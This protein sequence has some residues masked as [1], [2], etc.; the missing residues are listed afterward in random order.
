M[1]LTSRVEKTP[2]DVI[3][4][5]RGR[6]MRAQFNG[7]GR[8]VSI[9]S[10]AK[11]ARHGELGETEIQNKNREQAKVVA[12]APSSGPVQEPRTEGV[13]ES[14]FIKTLRARAFDLAAMGRVRERDHDPE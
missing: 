4:L 7:Y 11:E 5:S 2:V 14:P 8:I 9:A 1:W 12:R 3:K 10:K 6:A 13:G